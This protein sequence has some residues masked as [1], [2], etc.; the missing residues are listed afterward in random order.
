MNEIESVL[1]K[2]AEAF[3]SSDILWGV[4]ASVLLYE[5]KLID[6]PSDID[7][8]VSVSDIEKADFILS[9]LGEKLPEVK[10]EVYSTEYFYEYIIDEI[11]V[12]IIAGFRI[13]LPDSVFK[14]SFDSASVPHHFKIRSTPIPFSTLEEWFVLYQLMSGR[15]HKVSLIESYF[16]HNGIKYPSLLQRMAENVT[17]PIVAK[18]KL[19]KIIAT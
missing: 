5:Y 17:L 19:Q 2:I 9:S 10:S 13:N 3:S 18:E 1:I 4:G 6:N 11:E 7:I 12:D 16:K 14:Y 15:E 8:V